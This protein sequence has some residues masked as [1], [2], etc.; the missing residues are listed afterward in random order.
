MSRR[1]VSRLLFLQLAISTIVLLML[2][3]RSFVG[4]LCVWWLSLYTDIFI[5]VQSHLSKWSVAPARIPWASTALPTVEPAN[6]MQSASCLLALYANP[7]CHLSEWGMNIVAWL[8]FVLW[9]SLP[10]P[11]N[12]VKRS[13]YALIWFARHLSTPQLF[14]FSLF[15]LIVCG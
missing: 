3:L 7:F 6:G 8:E 4:F 2:S 12:A 13:R 14:V 9:I 5:S 1:R 15:Y 10:S 11:T